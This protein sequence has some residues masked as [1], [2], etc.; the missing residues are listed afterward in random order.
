MKRLVLLGGLLFIII[1]RINAQVT[2]D[3]LLGIYAGKY[4]YANPST[5]PWV[6]MDDTVKVS[7]ID[8]TNCLTHFNVPLGSYGGPYHTDYYS[9]NSTP[10]SNY[11]VKFYSGD[12]IKWI[13]DNEAQPP[14]NQPISYRFYGKRISNYVPAGIKQVKANSKQFIVYP[15][16]A[17]SVMQLS[18]NGNRLEE[19]KVFDVFGRDV[20]YEIIDMRPNTAKLDMSNLPDGVYFVQ[21]KTNEGS[22]TQKFIV[23]H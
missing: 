9:C 4:W 17:S 21:V 23:Q 10:P 2:A 8:S 22:S 1:I 15:N 14:P 7:M 6:V 5:S 13:D 18:V 3:S 16:P 12:S 20:R 11:Y 19:L